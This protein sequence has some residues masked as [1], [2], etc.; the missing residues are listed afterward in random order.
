M[1]VGSLVKTSY[2]SKR[3]VGILTGKRKN[4]RLGGQWMYRVIWADGSIVFHTRGTLEVINEK[5]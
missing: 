5:R 2:R 4:Y 3:G 1:K